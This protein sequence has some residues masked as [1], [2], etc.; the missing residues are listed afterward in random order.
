MIRK[1][2]AL[3]FQVFTLIWIFTSFVFAEDLIGTTSNSTM[4]DLPSASSDI[5]QL[6]TVD[7]TSSND[8]TSNST[9]AQ[10]TAEKESED[11]LNQVIEDNP[12]VVDQENL[13]NLA[14]DTVASS[15]GDAPLPS[16]TANFE[17]YESARRARFGER[18]TPHWAV[19]L[20]L[21]PKAFRN[22][23]F[24]QPTPVINTTGQAVSMKLPRFRGGT[25]AGERILFQ[26]LSKCAFG[27][28]GGAYSSTNMDGYSNLAIGLLTM[29]PYLN[30]QL[31][32]FDKQ[33]I[34]PTG[35]VKQEIVVQNYAYTGNKNRDL[36][37]VGRLDLGAMI[38]LNFLDK[39]DS[40]QMSANYGVKHTYLMAFWT[41]AHD[42][43][44]TRLKLSEHSY[45][46][47]FKFEF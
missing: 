9:T 2:I 11:E 41:V 26:T 14:D 29:G 40:S 20:V 33:W 3:I 32:F 15:S 18:N 8:Q 44:N 38:Y 45:R 24:R 28:E 5:E 19:N 35:Q 12:N 25:I 34:V 10:S 47:G 37:F 13:D 31:K 22:V 36:S 6:G 30:Y 7:D 39:D 1:G 27:L 17:A 42:F 16:P 23:E 43:S 4:S 46:G 21:Q